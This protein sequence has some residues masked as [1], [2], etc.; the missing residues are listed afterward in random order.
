MKKIVILEFT[1]Q[2]K[3]KQMKLFFVF[4]LQHHPDLVVDVHKNV[5]VRNEILKTKFQK[6][7][8]KGHE[9]IKFEKRK[10]MKTN[11]TWKRGTKS[12]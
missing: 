12:F 5:N 10:K 2:N 7:N 6:L 9:L 11:K 3:R 1:N 4:F 8:C